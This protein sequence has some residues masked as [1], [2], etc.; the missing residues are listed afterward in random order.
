MPPVR[1]FHSAVRSAPR[2]DPQHPASATRFSG[3]DARIRNDEVEVSGNLFGKLSAAA[4][5]LALCVVVLGA[6]VRLT[7]AGLGC[8][9]WPGCYGRL[10]VPDASHA[11]AHSPD[12]PLETGKAWREMTHRYA[13][14]TL[15]LV[16]L[17][18]AVVAIARRRDPAQPVA[19]PVALVFLVAAQAWL[20]RLTVTLLLQPLVVMG[21]LL[22]GLATLSLLAWL[23]LESRRRRAP[24][25]ASP[26]PP[27]LKRFALL[28]LCVLVVQIA[29]GGWTSSHYAAMACPDF[30]TCHGHWWP[31]ADFREGFIPW[32]AQ[33]ADF[34]GGTLEHPARVAIQV[35]HRVG[36]LAT[37]LVLGAAALAVIIRSRQSALRRSGLAVA[38]ALAVQIALGIAMVT[39]G[40][41]LY[42]AVAHNAVAALLLLSVV[43]MNHLL[44]RSR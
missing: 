21:H 25:P 9:D 27:A 24:A 30:P 39:H 18:L 33:V 4:T 7:H 42:V 2:F 34:T 22:G 13:A 20:G 35:T 11:A 10:V 15:G 28:A 38:L 32:R 44:W 43:T 29:L 40:L 19:I 36:A 6:Y 1:P 16:I 12:K 31:P 37:T 41:P 26:E 8:P 23:A 5:V 14:A 17:A 3:R